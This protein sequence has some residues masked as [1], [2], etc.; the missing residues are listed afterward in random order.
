MMMSSQILW[1]F[2]KEN[3]IAQLLLLPYISINSS[4]NVWTSRF[5]STEQSQSLWTSLVS[6]C[7]Q[8]NINI[9]INGTRF[10]GLLY[11][12]SDTT[13]LSKHLWLKTWPIE[14]NLLPNCRNFSKQSIRNLSKY[15][16]L[17]I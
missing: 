16:N 17:P 6:V 13:I 11:T 2:K 3:K 8:P 12:G 4:N 1:Q 15:S 7:A 14:K 9:K 5:G 10:S